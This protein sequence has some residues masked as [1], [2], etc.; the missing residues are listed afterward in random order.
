MIR[1]IKLVVSI[2]YS[3]ILKLKFVFKKMMDKELADICVVLYYHSVK[4]EQR[5]K[6]ARQMDDLI[7]RAKAVRAGVKGPLR[8]GVKHVAVTFDDGLQS[9]V[10]NALPELVLR[11]IPFTIFIPTGCLGC[12]PQWTVEDGFQ[13]DIEQVMTVDQLKKLPLNLASIGS[14]TMTHPR[15][16]LLSKEEALTELCGSRKTLESVLGRDIKLFSFPYGEYNQTLVQLARQTG[17]KRIF[18]IMPVFALCKPEEFVTGRVR[19][20]ATDWRLEFNLKMMGA[21]CWLP[22]AFSLKRKIKEYRG[23]IAQGFRSCLNSVS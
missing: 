21:Y 10:D 22:L 4:P 6:F 2:F 12:R 23:R 20:A 16:P 7:K 5:K 18:T 14:H 11:N 8:E 13:D 17:Y 15:L 3:F 9:V 19:V 1:I